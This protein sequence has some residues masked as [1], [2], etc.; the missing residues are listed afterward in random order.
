MALQTSKPITLPSGLVLPN[1]LV[2]AAMAEALAIDGLPNSNTNSVYEKWAEGG[3]GLVITGNVQL[4]E[5]WLGQPGDNVLIE[6]ETKMIEAWKVWAKACKGAAGGSPTIVQVNHPGRQSRV[7]AGNRGFFAKALAPSAVPIQLGDGLIATLASAVM[8]GTP[9]EMTV[10]DIEDVV[11]RFATT[12]RISAEAGFDGIEIHAAHGF[13]LAQFLSPK[14]NLR[15]D[16]YG[17]TPAKGAKIV[18]DII[19]AVREATP[20]GFTVGLKLNSVD[21]Q[22]E[23]EL[24]G[25]IEQLQV[26][27][28]TGIDFLEIS[29]GSYEEPLVSYSFFGLLPFPYLGNR[30]ITGTKYDILTLHD[31]A[32]WLSAGR[33]PKSLIGLEP[34]RRSS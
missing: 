26:I 21:H 15:N 32:R 20:K 27:V 12:A 22:V 11:K 25:S 2:K 24:R 19:Q 31:D 13:L 4:D 1:R 16:A 28:D 7:G 9:R 34:V 17:G 3:W 29:G 6:D 30:A 33:M 8:F 18:V 10:A 14:C 5:R 23:S